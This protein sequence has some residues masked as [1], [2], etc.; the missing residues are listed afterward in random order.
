MYM[1]VPGIR[2]LS[3]MKTEIVKT[4]IGP[5]ETETAGAELTFCSHLNL[6]VGDKN[7]DS[8]I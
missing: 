6:N 4:R 1:S 8:Q 2:G 5:S 7:Y 3:D